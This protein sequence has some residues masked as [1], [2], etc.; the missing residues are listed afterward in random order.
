MNLAIVV[1][2]AFGEENSS[3]LDL[4][5]RQIRRH[6]NVPYTIYASA[7]RL[8]PRFRSE[9]DCDPRVHV[10][11][12][13][14]TDLRNRYEHAHYLEHLVR[15]AVEDGATHIVTLHLDSF[16]VRDGWAQELAG[17]L[18]DSCV[19]ATPQSIHTA[20]LFFQRDFYLTHRPTFL[21]TAE[22]STDP[23]YARYLK[24]H[25][26]KQHSGVGYGFAAYR[27]D[28][29]CYWMQPTGTEEYSAIYDD[30][31]FHLG[32]A[33]WRTEKEIEIGPAPRRRH[34]RL[35]NAAASASRRVLPKAFRAFLRNRLAVRDSRFGYHMRK[36]RFVDTRR[37]LLENPETFLQRLRKQVA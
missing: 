25:N 14:D 22:V 4:H 17:R 21:P 1:V 24:E 34:V 36:E 35:A 28:L 30:L 5:L 11:E 20:C 3:L 16:P 9:L 12:C 19:L 18:S 26:P 2:Y 15:A 13:P 27:S 29:S 31:V 6:T 33:I 7:N 32:G 8:A 10:C 23:T 37:Q